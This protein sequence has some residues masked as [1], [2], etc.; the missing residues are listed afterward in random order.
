[1]RPRVGPSRHLG[2]APE[3]AVFQTNDLALDT[4]LPGAEMNRWVLATYPKATEDVLLSGWMRV[5]E[6][7][8]RRAAAVATTWG[9]GRLVLVG[10]RAQQRAQ[11]SA[12]FPFSLQRAGLVDGAAVSPLMREDNVLTLR[13]P[14]VF[15]EEDADR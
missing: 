12:T 15:T 14:L 6:Q 7:I 3:L 5:Q 13:P 11:T 4:T 1:M 10:F 8:A 9:K 2:A